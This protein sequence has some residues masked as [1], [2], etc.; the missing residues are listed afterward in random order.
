MRRLLG[1]PHHPLTRFI[2][3]SRAFSRELGT[4]LQ[5]QR[6]LEQLQRL[7]DEHFTSL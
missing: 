6:L 1:S 2:A 7:L 3:R 4:F 5:L